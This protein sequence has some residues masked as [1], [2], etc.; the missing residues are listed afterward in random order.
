MKRFLSIFVLLLLVMPGIA[1]AHAAYKDSS[2][3]DEASVAD[4]P[5]SVWAEYTEP[6]QDGSHLEI[7]D[8]CGARIDHDDTQITGYRMTISMTGDMSG[9]YRVTWVAASAIDPHVTRGAFTFTVTDGPECNRA[10]PPGARQEARTKQEGSTSVGTGPD[11]ASE[12]GTEEGARG[13]VSKSEAAETRVKGN[14]IVARLPHKRGTD[15]VMAQERQP[16]QEPM[17]ETGI[18]EG[19][20]WDW[21]GIAMLLSAAIG[22]AGGR[23]YAGIMGPR[24]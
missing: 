19:I 1:S 9:E 14:R 3:Q 24:R 18:W 10:A 8:P 5:G 11:E 22:A 17:R 7:Y 4:P 20:P 15:R 16:R 6:L 12:E 23:I 13:T 2:P 21:F